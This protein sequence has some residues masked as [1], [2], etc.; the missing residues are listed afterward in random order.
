[1][2]GKCLLS[3]FGTGVVMENLGGQAA[4]GVENLA[5][6]LDVGLDSGRFGRT[7]ILGIVVQV[8]IIV[9]IDAV[10]DSGGTV[11]PIDIVIQ[12]DEDQDERR[13]RSMRITLYLS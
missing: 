12:V 10:P 6:F 1:M 4:E 5:R 13:L 11:S 7:V 8:L 3:L 9:L 2:L